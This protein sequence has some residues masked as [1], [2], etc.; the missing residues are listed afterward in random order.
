MF[1]SWKDRCRRPHLVRRL[2]A[3]VL[4][5]SGLCRLCQ[6][7]YRGFRLRFHPSATSAS[8]WVDPQRPCEDGEFFA[9]YLQPGDVVVDVG[10]NIGILSL[11]AARAVG[12]AGKVY[13]VEAH[14]QTYYFLTG[15]LALNQAKNVSAHH[16]AVGNAVGTLQ[17]SDHQSDDLNTVLLD[18][19]GLAVPQGTLDDLLQPTPRVAL[20]KID[21]EGYEKFVLEGAVQTLQHTDLVYFEAWE[22]HFARFGYRFADV[23]RSLRRADFEVLR[24]AGA[25]HVARVAESYCPQPCQNLLAVRNLGQFRRRTGLVMEEENPIPE[26]LQTTAVA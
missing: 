11:T 25:G 20:L 19:R 4:W 7:K 14:P 21:V 15:N 6:F 16:L 24:L 8:L 26:N 10:A 3:R 13:A 12:P 9:A 23:W 22:Q 1:S 18:R 17:F 2:A 5:H